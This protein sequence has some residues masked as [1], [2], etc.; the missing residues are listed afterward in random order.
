MAC[1]RPS[2]VLRYAILAAA[3]ALAC[4]LS[5]TQ[6]GGGGIFAEAAAPP[7]PPSGAHPEAHVAFPESLRIGGG[8]AVIAVNYTLHGWQP[9]SA[10]ESAAASPAGSGGLGGLLYR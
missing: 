8:S 9:P 7:A 6:P 1:V 5:E 2:R 4:G 10:S 3:L